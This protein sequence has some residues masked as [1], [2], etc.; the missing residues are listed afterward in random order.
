M[1][2]IEI[3]I[4]ISEDEYVKGLREYNEQFYCD[5]KF[6]NDIHGEVRPCGPPTWA[7]HISA[8]A[9]DLIAY[10]KSPLGYGN[11]DGTTSDEELKELWP[12]LFETED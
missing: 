3:D 8:P 9:S 2:T 6:S 5:I 11:Y 10:L 4:A 1:K 12:E 7:V